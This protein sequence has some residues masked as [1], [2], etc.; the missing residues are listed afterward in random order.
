MNA[1]CRFLFIDAECTCKVPFDWIIEVVCRLPSEV[2]IFECYEC[3]G[4]IRQSDL[5]SCI[6]LHIFECLFFAT[7]IFLHSG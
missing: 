2:Y 1:E 4:I 7:Q 5:S 6:F 3:M